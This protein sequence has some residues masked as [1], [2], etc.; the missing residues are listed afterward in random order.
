M[1]IDWLIDLRVESKAGEEIRE[2]AILEPKWTKVF[3][4]TKKM[5]FLG[6]VN[7]SRKI[8]VI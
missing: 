1:S 2:Y 7:P 3:S 8:K 5:P 6:K 4:G